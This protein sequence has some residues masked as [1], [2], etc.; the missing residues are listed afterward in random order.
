[1]VKTDSLRAELTVPD[2]ESCATGNYRVV[3]TY[4]G[5]KTSVL[6]GRRDGTIEGVWLV[7]LDRNGK[8]DVIV[9]M[10]S[11]ASGS[12]GNVSIFRQTADGFF[13]VPVAGLDP[14]LRTMYGGHDRFEI[15]ADGRLVRAFTVVGT[16]PPVEI[17]AEY[18]LAENKWKR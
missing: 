11:T 1:M 16:A 3:I 17:R 18:S 7:D 2:G 15:T 8:L 6:S 9:P 14:D 13:K 4:P 10:A 12:Q 5:G